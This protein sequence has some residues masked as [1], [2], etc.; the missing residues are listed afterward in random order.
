MDYPHMNTFTKV[1]RT[2][3]LGALTCLLLL[4]GLV[5]SQPAA[6]QTDLGT[7]TG[8]VRDSTG[9]AVSNGQVE[10]RNTRTSAVRM[11]T[12][13]QNGFFSTPSLPVGPYSVTIKATGFSTAISN[14]DLT[15]SGA[16][17]NFALSVGS[18]QQQVNVVATA[19]AVAPQT[20]SH[21]LS[22]SV[23]PVQLVNLPNNGRS[24]LNIATLGP[25]SQPGTDVGV[26]V[27][28]TGFYGQQSNS[29]IISGLGN[30][31]ALFLQDGVDNTNLLTQTANILASVEATQETTTLLNG[32]PARFSQPS[33]IDVITKSGS[34][35]IH[36]TA[37]DFLQNDD[38]DATN[39]FATTKP[40]KRYNQFG[41]NI[42]APLWKSKLF[43]FFDY[44][45]LRSNT[46]SVYRDRVPTQQ[47][48]AGNFSADNVTIYNPAT[49]NPATGTSQAFAGDQ[50][51]TISAFAQQW[52]Q[53]YPL[54]NQALGADNVNYVVNL[55]TVS[56][57]DEYLGRVDYNIS[58]KDLLFGTVA[59]LES[60]TGSNSITPGLFGIFNTLKGTNISLAETHLFN[61]NI[62][63]VLR[64]GYNRS[65]LFRTQQGQGAQNYVQAYG[66]LN[67]TPLPS[68]WTPPAINL[69][70]GYTSLGDPYSP[71]GAIQNRFQYT[72]ELTWKAGNHT[73]ILGGELVR[74]Q[75]DGNWV[76]GN[77]GIYNFDGSATSLYVNGSRSSTQQGNSLADLELGFPRTANAANGVSVGAFRGYDVSG[78]VQDDWKVLPNLT[79]NIGLR[80]DFDNPPL[81]KNNHGGLFVVSSNAVVPGTWHTNYNDWG[82]R[83][84]FSYAVNQKTA[85]RGGY[86]IY[87]SPIL[88]NNLQFE[89]LY[90]PNF[91][92]QSYTFNIAN[93]VNIQHLFVANP[94]TAGQQNYTI[95]QTL[96]DTSVQ[97][98]NLN[99]ERSLSSN[100]LLTIGYIGNVTRH[101][102]GRA[103]LNQP[104]GLT[105]GN[106][107][108]ILDLKPNQVVGPTTGQLN[109]ISAN[110]NALIVKGERTM[111][112]GLQFLLSYT[113]SKALDILDGDNAN[114][115]DLY[116]PGLTY[117]PAGF[118]RTHSVVLSAIYQLP[119]GPGKPFLRS[120][121]FLNRELVGGWQLSGIQ[122]F[123]T[124]QPIQITA[125]NNADTSSVHSVYA[126]KVCDGEPP[127]GHPRLQYFNPSCFV[128]P[129]NGQ[130][131]TT[132][133]GPRQPGVDTTD[134]SLQKSFPIVHEQE[135]QFR[136]DAFSVFNHPNFGG[137]S[138]SV[139]NPGGGLLTRETVGS[140]ILQVALRYS[141]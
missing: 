25:A 114:I 92:N 59:R 88:Y 67:I 90:S 104:Y 117:G 8:S 12:T 101:Q 113:Y 49:Y 120:N 81:D 82:P 75:F 57:Y 22:T 9:A 122:Q 42:G 60:T 106:T 39:W 131:G 58:D 94:S 100:T 33:V 79:L 55:P 72:D 123:L 85:V 95:D 38:L 76:V 136:A 18:V 15:T 129:A 51:P 23:T 66:L 141:F 3:S 116:N 1:I 2:G 30:A 35:Q 40:A 84:G 37:Y 137:G 26:D 46:S 27:G 125:N 53:N 124:G 48:R 112:N 80:Y 70:N 127:A 93:P 108:G 11:T 63:N 36:G 83:V 20:D 50:I 62:V 133:S 109:A 105:A 61:D 130:Y 19:A 140:R 118:D 77:N 103:D 10:V 17:A 4:A 89:L 74:T 134:L 21:E 54:P 73:I 139:T 45:G 56:N 110:Y 126:L 115:Q 47:E 29:V 97:E 6:A 5:L 43:A 32:A 119:F 34:R 24:I 44:S 87:Y 41:A 13:D 99:V 98:W 68:Q 69:S 96:K 71:Q 14:V 132:R 28:D 64:V 91:V 78:Y 16:T 102:S 107:S 128:Q 7:I 31:H 65:N 52:L 135:L 86:G 121:N 138:V 111:S